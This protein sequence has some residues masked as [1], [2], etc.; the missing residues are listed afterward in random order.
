MF[1]SMHETSREVNSLVAH[2]NDT[3]IRYQFSTYRSQDLRQVPFVLALVNSFFG[4][5]FLF[6]TVFQ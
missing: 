3:T 2:L 1:T 6:G 4:T 5:I